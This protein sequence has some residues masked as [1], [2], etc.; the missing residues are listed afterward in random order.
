M[1]PMGGFRTRFPTVT[2]WTTEQDL[3]PFT[4]LPCFGATETGP[5]IR[6]FWAG[7]AGWSPLPSGVLPGPSGSPG[8][9]EPAIRRGA[10]AAESPFASGT[11]APRDTRPGRRGR[12]TIYRPGRRQPAGLGLLS[13][14]RNSEPEGLSPV[15]GR[16][17]LPTSRLVS[18]YLTGEHSASDEGA[19]P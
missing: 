6:W 4:F 7:A 8:S 5:S 16:N 15:P 17:T 12:V 1:F 2:P 14:S 18:A 19:L 13:R 9:R 10:P 11:S 3:R